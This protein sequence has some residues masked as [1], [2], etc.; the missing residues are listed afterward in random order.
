MKLY[1]EQ[2][3]EWEIIELEEFEKRQ[4]SG[5]GVKSLKIRKKYEGGKFKSH[6]LGIP[7]TLFLLTKQ[8]LEKEC[9]TLK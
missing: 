9:P 7:K 5:I 3:D 8:P 2:Y 4:R 6:R 1:N